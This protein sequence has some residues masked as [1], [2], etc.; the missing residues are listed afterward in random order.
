MEDFMI[1]SEKVAAITRGLQQAFGVTGFEDIRRM[2]RGQTSALVFRIVVRGCPYLLRIIMRTNSLV[3]P[4]RQFICMKAA[5]EAGLAPHV[6]YTSLEDQLAI[7]DFVEETPFSAADALSVMP[8]LLRD[9][10][11]LPPYPAGISHVDTSCMFLMH[12][13]PARDGFLRRFQE[14]KI[15]SAEETGQLFA[16]HAQVSAAYPRHD[17][18]MVSSHNDLKPENILFDGN[19]A[20]LIDWEAA[21]LNDRYA[22]LSALANF[23]VSGEM[24]EAVYLSAYFGQPPDEYQCARFFLMRQISH[25]FYAMA[26]LLLGSSGEPLNRTEEVPG[27]EAFHRRLWM[28]E[29]SL[30]DKQMKTVCGR[31]HWERLWQNMHQ[32]STLTRFKEALRIVSDRH[33]LTYR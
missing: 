21:F 23:I 13:G 26:Y 24:D 1:P 33:S 3:A 2:T 27:F 32:E 16:W 22:D 9:L 15:L 7:T 19:R 8:A 31:V 4:E 20:W 5:A 10:H 14:A 6:W 25:M 18:D 28:G 29:I 12:E 11:A 30:A 17:A